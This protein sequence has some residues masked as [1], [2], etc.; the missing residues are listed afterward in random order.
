MNLLTPEVRACVGQTA[1]FV[2]PE[3][4]G[5]ASIRYFALALGDANPL[6]VDDRFARAHGWPGVVAPPTLI[7]ETCQYA[8]PGP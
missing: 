2:A 8:P 4:L 1:D 7:C 3:P 5:R 6:W